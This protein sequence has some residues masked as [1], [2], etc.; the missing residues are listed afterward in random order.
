MFSKTTCNNYL[1]RILSRKPD[2]RAEVAGGTS[3]P[4]IRGTVYFYEVSGGVLL[5]VSVKGLPH[6]VDVCKSRIFGFHVHE[7]APCTGTAADQFANAGGHYNPH[8]C[9][10]PWHAGDLPPLFENRGQ[11]FMVFLTDRFTVRDIIGRTVII[12]DMPDNFTSQPSG[13]S[14]M[15]IA[16]GVIKA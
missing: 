13:D 2:A 8:G 4:K 7:G 11:A 5:M 1:K 6:N 3:Y 10:H 9:E 14:G 16:C 12:H 15:K